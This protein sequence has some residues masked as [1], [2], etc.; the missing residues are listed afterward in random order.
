[1]LQE[2]SQRQ[3]DDIADLET[4]I[5]YWKGDAAAARREAAY[6]RETNSELVRRVR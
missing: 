1:M 5:S 2:E 6:E 3:Q 4:Q